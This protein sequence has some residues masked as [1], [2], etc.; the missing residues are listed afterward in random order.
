MFADFRSFSRSSSLLPPQSCH[1]CERFPFGL[2]YVGGNSPDE[3]AIR[4]WNGTLAWWGVG[5]G[6]SASL[7]LSNTPIFK[8]DVL[9]KIP[10]VRRFLR[11]SGIPFSGIMLF[12]KEY[13]C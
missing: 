12:V 8:N 6:I 3:Q 10:V 2:T 7:L 1:M 9:I 5:I 4:A 11:S 13:G